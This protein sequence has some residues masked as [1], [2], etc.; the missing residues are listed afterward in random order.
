MQEIEFV[1]FYLYLT[2]RESE[3]PLEAFFVVIPE[4]TIP[5]GRLCTGFR[6][7]L[8]PIV[9]MSS[10]NLGRIMRNSLHCVIQCNSEI[11][12]TVRD[13]TYTAYTMKVKTHF[14]KLSTV[15]NEP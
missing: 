5:F 13:E 14:Q 9:G 4:I 3:P 6:K 8:I 10:R 15:M 12:N 7:K 1:P 2:Y 11:L